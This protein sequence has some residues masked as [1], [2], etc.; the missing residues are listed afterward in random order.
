[1]EGVSCSVWV[2][3]THSPQPTPSASPK[4][5]QLSS[6]NNQC[7]DRD[8]KKTPSIKLIATLITSVLVFS[9][10]E[11]L[12][13]ITGDFFKSV[14]NVKK[15]AEKIQTNLKDT[16]ESIDRKIQKVENVVNAVGDLQKELKN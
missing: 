16:R 4:T 14:D 9:G 11:M 8:V 1:M 7:Y 12:D 5:K 2:S 15:E 13:Q 10:C 3:S 6:A